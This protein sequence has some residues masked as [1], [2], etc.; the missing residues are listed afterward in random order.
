MQPALRLTGLSPMK[1]FVYL[2]LLP[3]CQLVDMPVSIILH[4]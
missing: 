4:S 3:Q 2:G 1:D